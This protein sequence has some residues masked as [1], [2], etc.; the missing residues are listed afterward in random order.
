MFFNIFINDTDSG[1]ERALSKFG[2]IKLSG[3]T[4]TTEGRDTI[5]RD[6]DR[7]EEWACGNLKRNDKAMCKVLHLGS[8]N[9]KYL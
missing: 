7:L 1:I 9:P 5:Q 8:G 3:A 6:L 4:D 2:D